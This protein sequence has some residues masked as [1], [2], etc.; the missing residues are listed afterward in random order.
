MDNN[1]NK[2][3]ISRPHRKFRDF[4]SYSKILLSFR[5]LREVNDID[6]G[7]SG[8]IILPPA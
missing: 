3:H 8:K 6:S 7:L 4:L 1:K 5:A 2:D